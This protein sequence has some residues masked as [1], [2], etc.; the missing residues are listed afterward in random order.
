[1]VRT[2][3]GSTYSCGEGGDMTWVTYSGE[4]GALINW[5]G[6]GAGIGGENEG[7]GWSRAKGGMA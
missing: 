7:L 3:V 2:R 5:N 4:V 1:M 6:D